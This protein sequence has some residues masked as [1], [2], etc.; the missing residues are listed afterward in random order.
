M[1]PGLVPKGTLMKPGLAWME[2]GEEKGG[3]G[4]LESGSCTEVGLS[5][6]LT[7][8]SHEPNPAE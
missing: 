1:F 3:E 5:L 6:A 8:Q 4:G 2:G 7:L